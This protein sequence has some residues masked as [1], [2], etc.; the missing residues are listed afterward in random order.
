MPILAINKKARYDYEILETFSAGL[1]LIGPEVKSA[2]L[3][4]VS[5]KGAYVV[6]KRTKSSLPSFE[7]LGATI[8]PYKYARNDEYKTDRSRALLL[9]KKELKYLLGKSEEKGL[10]LVPLKIYTKNA[11]VKLD[12]ALARGKKKHDK[13][14]AI[15]NRDIDR[16][17]RSLTR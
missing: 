13:R 4:Q 10:T 6:P 1:V 17:M 15:K 11:L 7:L 8:S 14:E 3:G 2:K 16:R 9:T 5:L 12:F